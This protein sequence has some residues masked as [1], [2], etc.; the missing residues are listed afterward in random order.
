MQV[1]ELRRGLNLARGVRGADPTELALRHVLLVGK[2]SGRPAA[3]V[4]STGHVEIEAQLG[5]DLSF[6]GTV[7]PQIIDF[8][9]LLPGE[10]KLSVTPARAKN[11]DSG[12]VSAVELRSGTSRARIPAGPIDWFPRLA[13]VPLTE[14]FTIRSD[15]LLALLGSVEAALSPQ[16]TEL[17][18]VQ[19]TCSKAALS[20]A[21]TD[22][23]VLAVA[24]AASEGFEG[25]APEGVVLPGAAV[26]PLKRLLAEGTAR[27]VGVQFCA[28]RL[29][30]V[31]PEGRLRA[32]ALT[33]PFP[34]WSQLLDGKTPPAAAIPRVAATPTVERVLKL[35]NP[36]TGA[37]K[38]ALSRESGDMTLSAASETTETTDSLAVK[39]A[40]SVEFGIDGRY[41]LSA[42]RSLSVDEVA[43]TCVPVQDNPI[44]RIQLMG[45]G[46]TVQAAW[47]IAPFQI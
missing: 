27:A 40:S 44:G 4:A 32:K 12:R 31:V 10:A 38:V 11:G 33:S 23:H 46:A 36:T 47:V 1:Q 20:A 42:L 8:V 41:L 39:A 45:K 2:E 14:R 25:A 34:K 26:S 18:G 29:E 37:L 28:N 13:D 21:V 35:A 15:V 5:C 6:S 3:V 17:F 24:T 7:A 19:L 16:R 22:G 30:V 43:L 9:G